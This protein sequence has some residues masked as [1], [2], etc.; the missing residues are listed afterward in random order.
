MSQ[1]CILSSE[2]KDIPGPLINLN[3]GSYSLKIIF[4]I[5][6]PLPVATWRRSLEKGSDLNFLLSDGFLLRVHVFAHEGRHRILHL[7]ATDSDST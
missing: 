2:A 5:V 4:F 7:S 1:A 6:Q 3:L